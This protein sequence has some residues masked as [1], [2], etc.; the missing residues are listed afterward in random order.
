MILSLFTPLYIPTTHSNRNCVNLPD[1]IVSIFEKG[2][3]DNE[4]DDM[5]DTVLVASIEY[6]SVVD[7]QQLDHC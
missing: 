3:K 1:V 7:G 2:L 4:S 5:W 6:L